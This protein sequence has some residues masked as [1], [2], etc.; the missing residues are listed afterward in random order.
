MNFFWLY[1]M[2]TWMMFLLVV[3]LTMVVAVGGCLFLRDRFDRWL[4]LTYETNDVVG[5]F[6]SFTGLF[7]GIL[8]GLVAVGAWESYNDADTALNNET[9]NVV[10]LYRDISVLP[11]PFRNKAKYAM[12]HYVDLVVNT[13]WPQQRVGRIPSIGAVGLDMLSAV[14]Y[15]APIN[16]A[17]D[18]LV[19]GT[20]LTQYNGLVESRRHRLATVDD[21]LP[22]SLWTVII[23]GVLINLVITWL[24]VIRNRRL[25]ILMNVLVS[26]A[27]GSVLA[28]IIAMDN[29]YRGELSVSPEPLA[30]ALKTNM[31]Y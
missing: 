31:A 6:L 5:N 9:A 19:V 4:G 10:A 25:D 28:F 20:A 26:A 22:S 12:R 8:L 3:S 18:E 27:L 24:F 16:N 14:L 21:G 15:A 17:H 1:D 2:P 7:F 13:E 23:L 11:D 30:I 29:P